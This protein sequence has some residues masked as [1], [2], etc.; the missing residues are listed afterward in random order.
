SHLAGMLG[1]AIL[2]K[3]IAEKWARREKDNRAVVFSPRGRQ[4][5]GRVFLA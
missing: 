3:I 5:F 2:D 4:E 1:A